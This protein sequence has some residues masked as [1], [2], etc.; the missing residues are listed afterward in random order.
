MTL[1]WSGCRNARDLGGLPTADGRHIREGALV[2][3]GSHDLLPETAAAAVRGGG[4]ARIVDLR[5]RS[6]CEERPSPF[7]GEPLYRHVPMV[8]EVLDYV[9]PPDTYA[10][11]L[12]RHRHRIGAAFR[13]VA[14][15]PSGAVVVHCQ[16]GRDRTGVLVALLLS[17]ARVAPGHVAEDYART[18][19]C[20]ARTMLSTLAHLE[21]RYAGAAAYLAGSGVDQGE[22]EAVRR[23]LV[24]RAGDGRRRNAPD[25][26]GT[27]PNLRCPPVP[28]T[29]PSTPT[30]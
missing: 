22:L 30:S 11:M 7:A 12:D 1:D 28:K 3:S 29:P 20:D 23:R 21:E 13:A 4:V 9:P 24:G 18:D 2:R 26:L 15:A 8:A 14:E 6:E 25:R 19:G 10:P 27:C 17:V 16:A 5:G